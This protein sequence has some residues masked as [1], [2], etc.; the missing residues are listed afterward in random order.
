MKRTEGS[1]SKTTGPE[2]SNI[3]TISVA[4]KAFAFSAGDNRTCYNAES[5]KNECGNEMAA[6]GDRVGI[7]QPICYGGR[8]GK[9]LLRLW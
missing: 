5:K 6:A 2:T 3:T 7:T 1:S 8:Q 9:E 4:E